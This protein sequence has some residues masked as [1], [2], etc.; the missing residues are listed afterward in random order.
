METRAFDVLKLADPAYFSEGR[1]V[2]HSDH[3]YFSSLTEAAQG[4][5]SFQKSLDGLWN[6]LFARNLAERPLNFEKPEVDCHDWK[7][8]RVPGHLQ[9]EGYG[10]PQ[11]TNIAYPWDGHELVKPGEIPQRENP[12][13]SYVKYFTV[14]AGWENVGIS[15][16]G[17]ESALAVWLNGHFVG[18]SEDTFTPSEFDLT[19]YLQAGEN[20]LAVQVYR[21]SSGSWIEDQDF[22]R[23]S[24][25]FREVY[26]YTKPVV[27]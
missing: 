24:G 15:F 17:A 12:T 25:L 21:F 16:Q 10:V 27:H 6:F 26:L 22:W 2:A 7:T 3:A 13:A 9:L 8:I 4:A 14:P 11:Y 19:P 20:K 5:S 18:Y 1:S 23:F